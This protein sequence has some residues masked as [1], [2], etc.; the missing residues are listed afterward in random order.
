MPIVEYTASAASG[1]L[2]SVQYFNIGN[3]IAIV[4]HYSATTGSGFIRTGLQIIN[5]ANFPDG[6]ES[7]SW[8]YTATGGGGTA[9][10]GF[11]LNFHFSGQADG[12]TGQFIIIGQ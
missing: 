1:Y 12:A 2:T 7:S 8:T 9:Y 10:A 4:G 6:D 3:Q 11:G 5:Y